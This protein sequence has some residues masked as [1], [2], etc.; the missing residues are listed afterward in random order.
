MG[1]LLH[2]TYREKR[3]GTYLH[4]ERHGGAMAIRWV[5]KDDSFSSRALGVLFVLSSARVSLLFS[6]LCLQ[7]SCC[8]SYETLLFNA[9]STDH[10]ESH[11]S[12]EA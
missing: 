12:I 9:P 7:A 1:D 4:R 2:H 8:V 5:G 11:S 6:F 3:K 10:D